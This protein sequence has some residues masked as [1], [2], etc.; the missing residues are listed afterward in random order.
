[1]KIKENQEENRKLVVS[2]FQC[3]NSCG[4]FKIWNKTIMNNL[5]L[6][7]NDNFKTINF[8]KKGIY[9]IILKITILDAYVSCNYFSIFQNGK[10]ISKCYFSKNKTMETIHLI[11]IIEIKEINESIQIYHPSIK[12]NESEAFDSL[13]IKLY[14]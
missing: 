9:E 14:V 6:E 10:E 12:F 13:T 8:K 11:E 4:I 2:K 1:M 7:L 3:S 5:H